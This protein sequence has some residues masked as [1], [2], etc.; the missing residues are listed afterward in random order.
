MQAENAGRMMFYDS[1]DS[2]VKFAV[3]AMLAEN[4]DK[5]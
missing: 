5:Y 2:C 4:A 3:F 1:Y